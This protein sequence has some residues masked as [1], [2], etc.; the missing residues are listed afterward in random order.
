MTPLANVEMDFTSETEELQISKQTAIILDDMCFL[1][2][3]LMRQV[4]RDISVEEK[5]KFKTTSIWIRDRIAA[6][7]EG[8]PLDGPLARDFI[9]KSCR[10]AAL[11][12]CKAI[13]ERVNLAK[14][15]TLS[16]LT[17][18]WGNMWRIKLSRWKQIPGIFLFILLSGIQAAQDTPH[19]RFMKNMMKATN[20]YMSVDSW[21]VVDAS[22]MTFMRLQRWL[23]TNG[24]EVIGMSKPD[25]MEFIH[26]YEQ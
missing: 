10:I 20:S 25:A 16:D 2:K 21:E 9:Y 26:I 23:R 15:C 19:G 13:V 17:Q 11:I 22:M 5:T 12:Y 3:Y 14:A 7:P 24:W 1:L 8:G 6:L 18:L 4:D